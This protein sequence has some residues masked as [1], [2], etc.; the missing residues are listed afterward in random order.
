MV[1]LLLL[2]IAQAIASIAPKSIVSTILNSEVV[3]SEENVPKKYIVRMC[4]HRRRMKFHRALRKIVFRIMPKLSFP[5]QK[6]I[7]FKHK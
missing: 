4:V 1:Y 6:K 7:L 5:Q 2:A 3:T